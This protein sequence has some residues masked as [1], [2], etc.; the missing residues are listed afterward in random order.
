MTPLTSP[1]RT[2][3]E[4]E[5]ELLPYWKDKTMAVQWGHYVS[6]REWNR[7]QFEGFP[8][9]PTTSAPTGPISSGLDRCDPAWLC[10]VL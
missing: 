9:C 5:E 3:G 1:T 4:L 6:Q 10:Q 8:M 2:I 7:G